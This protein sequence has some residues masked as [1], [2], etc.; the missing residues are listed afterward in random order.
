MK[1]KNGKKKWRQE[2]KACLE[3]STKDDLAGA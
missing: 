2:H 1:G 3:N